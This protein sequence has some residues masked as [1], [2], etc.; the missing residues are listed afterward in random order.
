MNNIER[1]IQFTT[2]TS[3][4]YESKT[5]PTLDYQIWTEETEIKETE[6]EK[7]ADNE[8]QTEAETEA[9]RQTARTVTQL[10]YKFFEKTMG[11]R[12]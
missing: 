2:E 10:R 3:E 6:Q 8:G 1:D 7:Q 12:Y 11:S 9:T 4:D 5:L